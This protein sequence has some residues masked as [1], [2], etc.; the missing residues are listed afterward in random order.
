MEGAVI[1]DLTFKDAKLTLQVN[2]GIRVTGGLLAAGAKGVTLRN[3]RFTGLTISS[4]NGDNG[5]ADYKLGDLFGSYEGCSFEN[6]SAE[7][8]VASVRSPDKLRLAVFVPPDQAGAAGET[9][10]P[11]IP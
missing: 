8:L 10:A 4:G 7:G 11:E 9:P 3:C 6:C 1:S 2:P 5:Q